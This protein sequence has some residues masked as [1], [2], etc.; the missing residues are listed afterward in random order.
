MKSHYDYVYIICWCIESKRL[1][2]LD[3]HIEFLNTYKYLSGKTILVIISARG[4]EETNMLSKYNFESDNVDI[5]VDYNKNYGGTV[6]SLWDSWKKI[7]SG[8]ITSKYVITVEDDWVFSNFPKR[9]SLLDEG[10]IYSGM[11]S[12]IAGEYLKEGIKGNVKRRFGHHFDF[13]GSN[14]PVW[15]D[16]GLYF[17]KY[18]SLKEIENAIGPFTNANPNEAYDHTLHGIIHGEVGFPARLMHA[19][20]KFR[21]MTDGISEG[22]PGA[23]SDKYTCY[24]VHGKY[25]KEFIEV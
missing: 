24:L 10:Y 3:A 6:A 25:P 9:E 1:N 23:Y 18:D 20:F 8:K 17:L 19:G 15:T 16:G 14:D 5:L 2:H 22:A 13:L 11:F 21:A 7:L 12:H 4:D